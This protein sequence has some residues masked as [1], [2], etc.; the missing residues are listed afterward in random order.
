MR[1]ISSLSALGIFGVRPAAGLPA[2]HLTS[3]PEVARRA[4]KEKD[5]SDEAPAKKDGESSSSL[6][7]YEFLGVELYW[8]LIILTG[9]LLLG[10]LFGYFWVRRKREREKLEEERRNQE[11]LEKK[12]L[13]DLRLGN[14]PP[15]AYEGVQED[16]S[17]Q[18]V[19]APPAALVGNR[20]TNRSGAAV[21]RQFR[22][23]EKEE[24]EEDEEEDEDID[25]SDGSLYEDEVYRQE[26]QP[27]RKGD[28]RYRRR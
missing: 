22:R 28:R 13:R 6:S 15:D 7:Q 10:G 5:S 26:R 11:Y 19:A 8:W 1:F 18:A 2:L 12:Y 20:S 4:E 27:K 23:Q 3:R 25:D 16:A 24:E 17:Q 21:Q 9:L 14:T